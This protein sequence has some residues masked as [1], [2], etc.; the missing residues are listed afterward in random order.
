MNPGRE[1][2]FESYQLMLLEGLEEMMTQ[3]AIANELGVNV[4][5]IQNWNKKI[6]W[7]AIKAKRREKYSKR[8][9]EVDEAMFRA[10]KKGDVNAAKV[11]YERFDGWT[12]TTGTKNMDAKDS[13]LLDEAKKIREELERQTGS[14]LPGTSPAQA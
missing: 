4:K 14:N 1:F 12:P 3:Q 9:I 5:T 7:E 13:E 10:A 6:D 2:A 11:W 8:T